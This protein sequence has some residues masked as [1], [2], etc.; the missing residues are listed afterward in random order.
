MFLV[1]RVQ[2]AFT[3]YVRQINI[4]IYILGECSALWGECE[5]VAV[6]IS[7]SY[8]MPGEEVRASNVHASVCGGM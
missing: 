8:K 5:R 6:C 7:V 1:K 4:Y 3:E 2:L